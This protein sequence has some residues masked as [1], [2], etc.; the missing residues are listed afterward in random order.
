MQK[1]T[2]ASL[3]N[4]GDEFH[5]TFDAAIGHVR[6]ELGETH[7]MYINGK[8]KKAKDGTF[9]DT[10]PADTRI[11]LGKFQKGDRAD[12][13]KGGGG[14]RRAPLDV[15]HQQCAAAVADHRGVAVGAVQRHTGDVGQEALGV[16]RP[17][18]PAVLPEP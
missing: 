9:D 13:Q 1:I 18:Q 3:A 8:P 15:D 16:L 10:S 5:N 11:L 12:A 4:L 2:Y 6:E 17:S 7:P 14:V